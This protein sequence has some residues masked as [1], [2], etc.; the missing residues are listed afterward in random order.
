MID[1]LDK[2]AIRF[3]NWCVITFLVCCGSVLL[4]VF[5]LLGY[6]DTK[7]TEIIDKV[8]NYVIDLIY[9]DEKK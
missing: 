3:Y 7:F 6:D 9:G 4:A 8:R 1:K 5:I 2:L